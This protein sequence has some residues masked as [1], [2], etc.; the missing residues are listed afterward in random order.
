M[1][2]QDNNPLPVWIILSPAYHHISINSQPFLVGIVS[3]RVEF[4]DPLAVATG[5]VDPVVS[6]P[7]LSSPQPPSEDSSKPHAQTKIPNVLP[8]PMTPA[9]LVDTSA[10]TT[11]LGCDNNPEE[12]IPVSTTAD[13]VEQP[14]DCPAEVF[15]DTT[16]HLEQPAEDD[17][18]NDLFEKVM[19][20]GWDNGI[21]ILE[22]E[23][24]T[25]ETS[26]LP[27]TLVKHDYPYAVAQY[28]LAHSMGTWDGRHT[29][30]RYMRWAHGLLQQANRMIHRLH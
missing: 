21:L 2:A 27:F 18:Q 3:Q 10:S 17:P 9:S 24:K 1:Y 8:A 15:K 22:I 26:S 14:E 19:A 11:D 30:G 16:H 25:G 20:H 12:P 6:P 29:S 7:R 28:I 4:T 23:W 5:D 13:A